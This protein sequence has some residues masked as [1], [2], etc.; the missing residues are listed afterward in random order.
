MARSDAVGEQTVLVDADIAGVDIA[1]VD[2]ADAGTAGAG[3]AGAAHVRLAKPVLGEHDTLAVSKSAV[4]ASIAESQEWD[5][6]PEQNKRRCQVASRLV[7]IC[8]L[9]LELG[10]HLTDSALC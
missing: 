6:T 3:T 4:Q 7:A 5:H 2:I 9:F 10:K 1:G 8:H